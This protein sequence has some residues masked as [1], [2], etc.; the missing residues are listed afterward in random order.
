M[1]ELKLKKVV[2]LIPNE[3]SF[4]VDDSIEYNLTNKK[5]FYFD[6]PMLELERK[7][8]NKDILINSIEK[9]LGK[10][11]KMTEA[12]T[13]PE[14]R[15]ERIIIKKEEKLEVEFPSE[16]KDL[17]IY[18]GKLQKVKE[19]KEIVM[20]YGITEE[21]KRD[22]EKI[23]NC[24]SYGYKEVNKEFCLYLLERE[25]EDIKIKLKELEKNKKYRA[26]EKE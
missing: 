25:I 13:I 17:I 23:Y 20:C 7:R 22:I 8:P 11:F 18:R 1:T 24:K 6:F 4:I 3:V 26:N 19:A 2:S 9:L 21:E 12:Y 10:D 5:I 15:I 14:K 16:L